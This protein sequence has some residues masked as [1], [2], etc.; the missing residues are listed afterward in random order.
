M[1]VELS[2]EEVGEASRLLEVVAF[3]DELD[4]LLGTLFVFDW[5]AARM[6]I[7]LPVLKLLII[8]QQG[9]QL[10]LVIHTVRLDRRVQPHKVIMLNKAQRKVPAQPP[11]PRH[12][13]LNVIVLA[14]EMV[15]IDILAELLHLDEV[16]LLFEISGPVFFRS[17]VDESLLKFYAGFVQLG[18]GEV[19]YLLGFSG[20]L[21]ETFLDDVVGFVFDFSEF[22]AF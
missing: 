10:L 5:S 4:C 9:L 2:E 1:L 15:H 14:L 18:A 17:V 21:F 20:A 16:P 3:D 11:R 8:M 6:E 19:V 7:T 12:P 13:V 22:E